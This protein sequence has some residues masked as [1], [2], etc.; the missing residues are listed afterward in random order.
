ML[1][2]VFVLALGTSRDV[3]H[4]VESTLVVGTLQI[5][6]EVEPTGSRGFTLVNQKSTVKF[7]VVSTRLRWCV[8]EELLAERL[9]SARLVQLPQFPDLPSGFIAE[10]ALY[11]GHVLPIAAQCQNKLVDSLQLTT[12]VHQLLVELCVGL[13]AGTRQESVQIPAAG[14]AVVRRAELYEVALGDCLGLRRDLFPSATGQRALG[15]HFCLVAK[16]SKGG[17]QLLGRQIVGFRGL[18]ELGGRHRCGVV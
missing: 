8:P 13:L 10:R 3:E 2:R 7:R 17:R 11:C 18:A 9:P 15:P 12:L 4:L 14:Q 16:T 1:D 5:V 6:L